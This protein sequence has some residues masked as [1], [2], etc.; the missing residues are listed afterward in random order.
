MS[1]FLTSKKAALRPVESEDYKLIHK[2]LNDP[3][4]TRYMFYGQTPMNLEQVAALI[5][6]QVTAPHNTVFI[7]ENHVNVPAPCGFAGLYNIHPTA[8]G[9]EF[10]IFLDSVVW[11]NG[12]GTEVT[13]LLT[14]YG[15]D[16]LNL[17][18][19]W[20][21]VTSENKGAVRTYEK[22]GYTV[23]GVLRDDIYR[24]SRYYDSIRMAILRDEYYTKLFEAHKK[25]FA[26]EPEEKK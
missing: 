22:A 10:R 4:N 2:W 15:F 9:A 1:S 20:L 3:K 7:V 17:H 13:E 23:E 26:P 14:F 21:G 16:R 18:R 5:S 11:G 19:I 8:R 25:R 6:A 24:N 12:I